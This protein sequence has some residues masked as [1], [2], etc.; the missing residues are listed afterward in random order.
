MKINDNIVYD[1]FTKVF[2]VMYDYILLRQKRRGLGVWRDED[3]FEFQEKMKEYNDLVEEYKNKKKEIMGL[4]GDED[5]LRDYYD[6]I[7]PRLEEL[8]DKYLGR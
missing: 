2:K 8:K 5:G 1:V 6:R 4:M 7:M 3:E